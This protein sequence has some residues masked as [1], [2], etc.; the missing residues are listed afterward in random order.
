MPKFA[1]RLSRFRKLAFRIF[2][3]SLVCFVL[4]LIAEFLISHLVPWP[5]QLN[6]LTNKIEDFE[7]S[8]LC[9]A[10]GHREVKKDSNIFLFQ[11][12]G[13]DRDRIAE[14]ISQLEQ[15]NVRA[16]G[17]DLL[18]TKYQCERDER[19]IDTIV[20][21][22]K[23][24]VLAAFTEDAKNDSKKTE[25]YDSLNS[26]NESIGSFNWGYLKAEK[27][28][29]TQRYYDPFLQIGEDSRESFA[30]EILQVANDES[31]NKLANRGAQRELINFRMAFQEGPR[32][33]IFDT[34]PTDVPSS[35]TGK[36]V[37]IG[38]MDTNSVVDRYYTPLNKYIGRSY[39]DMDGVEW[40]AQV[41]SMIMGNDYLNEPH[42]ITKYVLIFVC[43]YCS[44]F[45]FNW[46][47]RFESLYHFLNDAFFIVVL[48]PFSMVLCLTL[49]NE[50]NYKLEPTTYIIPAFFSGIALHFY[51]P[52]S[53]YLAL[54]YKKVFK[55]HVTYVTKQATK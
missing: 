8:D 14:E 22:K 31:L 21:Y 32:Y 15:N 25:F 42:G 51:E 52:V 53:K 40:H 47:Y 7:L 27:E 36:I 33:Q 38:S 48:V 4:V 39:P 20:K 34:F 24:I 16:I 6:P 5:E 17:I 13:I 46:W 44:M 45:F 49:L 54:F 19:L 50:F 41:L 9:F 12:E 10:Y 23:N 11:W 2:K 1:Q 43:V 30:L 3:K 37:L 35:V 55:K 28:F 29:A 26:R 18:F